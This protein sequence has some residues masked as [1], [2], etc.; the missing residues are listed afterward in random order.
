MSIV[1]FALAFVIRLAMGQQAALERAAAA[2]LE[3]GPRYE[4]GLRPVDLIHI[5]EFIQEWIPPKH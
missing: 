3:Q 4:Q 2:F 1:L 5:G